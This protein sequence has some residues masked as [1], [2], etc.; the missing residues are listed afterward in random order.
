MALDSWV[1]NRTRRSWP[2]GAPM[3]PL[4]LELAVFIISSITLIVAIPLNAVHGYE[5][6][7]DLTIGYVLI[8]RKNLPSNVTDPG[9]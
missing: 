4:Y 5:L 9:M 3:R 8:E 2:A 6:D 7:S 1:S